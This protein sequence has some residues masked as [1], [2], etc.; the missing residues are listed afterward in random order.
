MQVEEKECKV[1]SLIFFKLF[2][3]LAQLKAGV[4]SQ[5]WNQ[6][7]HG[8]QYLKGKLLCQVRKSKWTVLFTCWLIGVDAWYSNL[9]VQSVV[10]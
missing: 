4:R 1:Y 6:V 8:D 9:A 2:L 10:G 3:S 5:A 7:I